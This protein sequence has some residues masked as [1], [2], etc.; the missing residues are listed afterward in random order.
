MTANSPRPARAQLG[1]HAQLEAASVETPI[2]ETR[3]PLSHGALMG[4]AGRRF[5]TPT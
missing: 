4:S 5:P 2:P 1:E 3:L